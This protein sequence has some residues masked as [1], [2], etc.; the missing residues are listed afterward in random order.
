MVKQHPESGRVA[1][2]AR[3]LAVHLVKHAVGEVAGSLE[4]EYP[5]RDRVVYI[6]RHVLSVHAE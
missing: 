1:S 4:E 3:L 2:A 5:V 6:V